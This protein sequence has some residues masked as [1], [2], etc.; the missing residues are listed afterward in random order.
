[1]FVFC[2]PHTLLLS[3]FPQKTKLCHRSII[4]VLVCS[5]T[6]MFAICDQVPKN[7][8]V[9]LN[10]WQ[11]QHPQTLL[12]L[13]VVGSTFDMLSWGLT[14]FTGGST[15]RSISSGPSWTLFSLRFPNSVTLNIYLIPHF[16]IF[17]FTLKQQTVMFFIY[18]HYKEPYILQMYL[19]PHHRSICQ[20]SNPPLFPWDRLP[21]EFPTSFFLQ[22]INLF[23]SIFP[24]SLVGRFFVAGFEESAEQDISCGSSWYWQGEVLNS[25]VNFTLFTHNY[26]LDTLYCR[27]VRKAKFLSH[28]SVCA[29]HTCHR[30]ALSCAGDALPLFQTQPAAALPMTTAPTA[31]L[32]SADPLS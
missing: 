30:P 2:S 29:T 11:P 19:S 10:Q 27:Y 8:E 1:M 9:Q 3:C 23:K 13:E 14:L 16:M 24:I 4:S 17:S 21:F 12:L 26:S 20:T 31:V 5:W 6:D 22:V 25:S 28:V 7:L 15:F 18:L 32:C